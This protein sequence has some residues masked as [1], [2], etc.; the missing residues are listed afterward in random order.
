VDILL[1]KKIHNFEIKYSRRVMRLNMRLILCSLKLKLYFL[2][3]RKGSENVNI[4]IRVF[5]EP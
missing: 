2:F 4:V 1:L 5:A 3:M